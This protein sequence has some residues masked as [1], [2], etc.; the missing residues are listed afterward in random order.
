M[1]TVIVRRVELKCVDPQWIR[2]SVW[3]KEIDIQK[4]PT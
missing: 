4:I 2:P 3:S 1:V